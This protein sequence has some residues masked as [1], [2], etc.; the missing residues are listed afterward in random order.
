MN[1]GGQNP[2]VWA[3]AQLSKMKETICIVAISVATLGALVGLL[4]VAARMDNA[5]RMGGHRMAPALGTVAAPTVAGPPA[6]K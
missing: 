3:L 4:T 6:T 1:M 2:L 5:A